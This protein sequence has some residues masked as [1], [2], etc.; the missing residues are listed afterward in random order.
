MKNHPEQFKPMLEA[1]KKAF[2]SGDTAALR[3]RS[4]RIKEVMGA[5]KYREMSRERFMKW[6]EKNP[7]EYA[8]ARKKNHEKIKTPESQ[9]KRK[10][11]LENWVKK[12][13]KNIKLGRKS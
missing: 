1:S 6:R 7:E 11:S 8:E 13:Q 4:R 12:T 10:A 5:E 9:A 2:W 3:A